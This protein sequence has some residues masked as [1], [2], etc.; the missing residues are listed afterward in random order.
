MET[1]E[2]YLRRHSVLDG[3]GNLDGEFVPLSVAMIGAKQVVDGKIS[4]DKPSWITQ[5]QPDANSL[6]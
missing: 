5:K 1:L 3:H 4:L 2:D 6:S